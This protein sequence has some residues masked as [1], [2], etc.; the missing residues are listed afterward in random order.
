M[1]QL[2]GGSAVGG[3][4]TAQRA[5]LTDVANERTRIDIPDGGNL[6]A[7]EIELRSFRGTPIGTDLRE[8]AND[9]GFNVRLLGLFIVK[10]RANISDVGIGEADNLAGVTGVGEYFLISGEAGVKNDFTAAARDRA[11]RAAVKYAPVFQGENRRSMRNFRQ[12]VLLNALGDIVRSFCFR[13]RSRG[14]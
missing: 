14:H 3:D 8:L 11:G 7:V 1:D 13:L 4:D 10:I 2:I 9:E 5:H 12:C 6:V